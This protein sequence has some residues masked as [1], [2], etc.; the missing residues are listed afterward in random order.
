MGF[1]FHLF[2][3]QLTAAATLC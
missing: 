2:P 1:G 3:V